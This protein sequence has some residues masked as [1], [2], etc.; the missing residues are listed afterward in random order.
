MCQQNCCSRP[1]ALHTPTPTPLLSKNKYNVTA[2]SNTHKAL[3]IKT[4]LPCALS[5]SDKKSYRRSNGLEKNVE[6]KAVKSSHVLVDATGSSK[7]QAG[8]AWKH[9]VQNSHHVLALI[10]H[11]FTSICYW[12]LPESHWSRGIFLVNLAWQLC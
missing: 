9:V 3:K 5:N 8:R 2:C 1:P 11:S 12:L 4:D 7:P 6:E 10:L